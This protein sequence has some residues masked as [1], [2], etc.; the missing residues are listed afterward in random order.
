MLTTNI[1]H[2]KYISIGTLVFMLTC[3]TCNLRKNQS[4]NTNTIEPEHT[5]PAVYP[6]PHDD[7]PLIADIQLSSYTITPITTFQ[8][9]PKQPVLTAKDLE[10]SNAIVK[11]V[12][13]VN[14]GYWT[15]CGVT[16]TKHSEKRKAA[17]EWAVAIN[18]AHKAT[19]YKVHKR[20]KPRHLNLV[21]VMGL[22][23]QESGLDRC[24]VGPYPRKYAHKHNLLPKVNGKR[25][26]SHSLNTW[27]KVFTH[28]RFKNRLADLGPGQIVKR[29]GTSNFKWA[30]VRKYMSL[31]PGI[32]IVFTELAHRGTLYHTTTP[33]NYWPGNMPSRGYTDK[34]RKHA[35]KLITYNKYRSIK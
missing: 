17:T 35:N 25:V 11:Y 8:A 5:Y 16:Y 18:K 4:A 30:D 14:K 1:K 32:Q 7:W 2:L 10:L 27:K 31:T 21:A 22:L 23:I 9:S 29:V 3:T 15:E 26:L 24:A 33:T 6:T 28:P 12:R 19:T 20:S 34:I 13:Y